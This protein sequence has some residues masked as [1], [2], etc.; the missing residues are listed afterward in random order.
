[1]P[2]FLRDTAAVLRRELGRLV[3]Q[4]MYMVLMLLLPLLSFTFFAVLFEKGVAHDIPIAVLD[5]DRTTLSRKITDMV[6][7]T[8][9]AM[10]SFEVQTMEQAERLMREGRIMA[11]VQI[12][13]FFEKNILSNRQTHVEA[14]I[15][16]TN[17][18]VNGLLAR[19]IQTAVTT[20]SAGI[21]LQLLTKQGLTDRQAMA[22]L[23]P[24]RFNKHVLFNPYTNYGYYLSPSFMP[25]MLLIFVVMVTVFTIGT[26]LKHA[27]AREWLGTGNGSVAAAL[28]LLRRVSGK[29]VRVR[30][31]GGELT[32]D[33]EEKDGSIESLY[34]TGPAAMVCAGEILDEAIL[35]LVKRQEEKT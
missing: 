14:Y 12:P 31:D 9:T 22:Q 28:T 6:D 29:N 18:T 34:L 5:E 8:P 30:M 33:A 4:P 32:V 13:D 24:V 16:G 10:V 21:Q 3:R 26:E 2:S 11:I 17:I 27:T 1:M 25:M 20:F 7:A 35:K 15:T 19:D 23:M